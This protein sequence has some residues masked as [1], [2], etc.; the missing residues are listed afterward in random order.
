MTKR[1]DENLL[2]NR[3]NNLKDF[4]TANKLKKAALTVIA[5]QLE[6]EKIKDLKHMFDAAAEDAM[7]NNSNWERVIHDDVINEVQG[8]Y[9]RVV[10]CA[11]DRNTAGFVYV[12]TVSLEAGRAAGTAMH[13]RFF[14][15]QTVATQFFPESS[16]KGKF[17]L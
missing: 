17:G 15:G 14:G 8:R 3:F 16:Y 11:V 4:I 10:H 5:Q 7:P 6:E 9:G 1:Q 2:E 12:M 13:G